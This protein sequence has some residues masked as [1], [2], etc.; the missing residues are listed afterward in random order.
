MMYAMSTSPRTLLG[1]S[2]IALGLLG[3]ACSAPGTAATNTPDDASATASAT[4]DPTAS[5]TSDLPDW[6]RDRIDSGDLD[7]DGVDDQLVRYVTGTGG[8]GVSHRTACEESARLDTVWDEATSLEVVASNSGECDGWTLVTDGETTSW[9]LNKYLDEAK[10]VAATGGGGGGGGGTSAG[11]GWV[12]VLAY[13]HWQIPISKLRVAEV[14]ETWC[15]ARSWHDPAGG[16]YVTETVDGTAFVN[17]DPQRCG[18][19]KVG[20]LAVIWVPAS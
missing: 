13:E 5:P 1:I 3:A 17:P 9:V 6:V 19:G 12:Q 14:G 7:G 16:N 20:Q 8:G 4:D 11:S 18:F 2:L 15:D 10:P